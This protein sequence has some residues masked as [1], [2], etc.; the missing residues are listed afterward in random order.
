MVYPIG[1]CVFAFTNYCVF[2]VT[3]S[4]YAVTYTFTIYKLYL[5]LCVKIKFQYNVW[6]HIWNLFKMCLNGY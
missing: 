3:A 6:V 5:T 1:V 2:V 4:L